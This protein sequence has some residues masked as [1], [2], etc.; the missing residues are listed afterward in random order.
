MGAKDKEA[1]AFERWQECRARLDQR[2]IAL[3]T[4]MAEYLAGHTPMPTDLLD[5][6]RILQKKCQALFEAL[7]K[8]MNTP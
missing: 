6:V 5:E 3:Q 4:E 1:E 7:L 8:A 2:T